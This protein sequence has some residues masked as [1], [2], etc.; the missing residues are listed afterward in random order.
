[1]VSVIIPSYNRSATIKR[2]VESVLNQTYKNLEVIVVDD[3]STDN[4]EEV[5][6]TINDSRLRYFC[7]D[8]NSGA[9]TARNKGIELAKG[10]YIAFQ[11]SDDEWLPRKLEIQLKAMK[12]SGAEVSFCKMKDLDYPDSHPLYTPSIKKSGIVSY[13]TLYTL[14]PVGT[15]AIVAK[16][17]V[18]E[19]V[20]FD[21]CL[22]KAQDVEWTFRAGRLY[23][24]YYVNKVLVHR[25]LQNDSITMGGKA[26]A[27]EAHLYILDKYR[28]DKN[29][30]PDFY[31]SRL[32]VVGHLKA[33][34]GINP[35]E[36]FYEVYKINGSKKELI[37][38]YLSKM[39]L[40]VPC[41]KL[42]GIFQ[43]YKTIKANKQL[44]S[45]EKALTEKNV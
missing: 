37:K 27:L 28:N 24:F 13:K 43:K 20:K 3:C 36:E 6:K 25:Y 22:R 38:Y 21:F 7:L 26:K 14:V 15:Q 12:K 18:F 8:K 29:E 2:S 42:F 33:S 19:N 41:Y 32:K 5:L 1:M 34:N 39:G 16:R 11:D 10:E 9:C 30:Y 44:L 35:S 4:T 23:K 17:E 40:I 45:R 31:V